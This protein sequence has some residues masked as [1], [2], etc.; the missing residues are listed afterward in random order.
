[1]SWAEREN[2]YQDDK[3]FDACGLFGFIDTTGQRHSG[4][5]AVVALD[6]RLD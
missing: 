2:H 5:K 1:M 3:V 4:E 6:S